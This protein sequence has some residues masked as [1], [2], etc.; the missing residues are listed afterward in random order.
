MTSVG[1]RARP[2]RTLLLA[3]TLLPVLLLA[4]R[5]LDMDS[6][7]VTDWLPQ[8]RPARTVYDRFVAQF[9]VDDYVLLSWPGCILDDPRVPRLAAALRQ[10]PANSSTRL[11]EDVTTGP[12]LLE[13]LTT[14]PIALPYAEA[15][16]RIRGLFVGPDHQTTCLSIRTGGTAADRQ[17]AFEHICQTAQETCGLDRG[18]L[19]VGGSTFE[20]VALNEASRRTLLRYAVPSGIVSLIVALLFQANPRLTGAVFLT[21]A[22][23]QLLA[24]AVL[25]VTLGRM[26]VLLI[27]M[28]TLVYVLTMSGAVHLA[29]YCLDSS[30]FGGWRDGVRRGMAIGRFPVL[31]TTGTTVLGVLSLCSSQIAP[32]RE[33]G[34]YSALSL[35]LSLWGQFVLL[36]A[37][38]T[39]GT[40]RRRDLEA[41]IGE[42]RWTRTI[43]SAGMQVAQ[44][45]ARRPVLTTVLTLLVVGAGAC[46]LVRLRASVDFD[47]MFPERSEVIRNFTWLE[48]SLGP[49]APIEV[50]ISVPRDSELSL[51]ECLQ[52]IDQIEQSL[53]SL[54]LVDGTLSAATY[55][56]RLP[57]GSRLQDLIQRRLWID[58]LDRRRPEFLRDHL[59]AEDAALE[60]WRIT[61]R[62]PARGVFEYRSLAR[63]AEE[64][65]RA[66]IA[67]NHPGGRPE[68]VVTS[69]GMLTVAEETNDQLFADLR[70]S[71]VT[72]FLLITPLM[73]LLLGGI[74]PGLMAMIPNVTPIMLVF[75]CMGWLGIP[76]EIGTILCASVALGI[77]VDDT[78]HFLTW[79]RVGIDDG[80]SRRDAVLLAY[81][82]C[83]VA[84]L[85][86]TMIC[87]CG[88]LVFGLSD[89]LPAARF[90]VLL[91]A[92]L[93]V[94]LLGDLVLLP[95]L[96]CAPLGRLFL[97][98]RSRSR[99]PLTRPT[100]AA[101]SPPLTG[102]T[103]AD[104]VAPP[105]IC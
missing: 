97:S 82:R 86:T 23:C 84:M 32:V 10:T 71:F 13:R 7:R 29:N 101:D 20:A 44:R 65:A 102:P 45:I 22:F 15:L 51:W 36:P 14:H 95:A 28:P 88:M 58:R 47:R 19:R 89:F 105:G 35:T 87:V 33:F 26:N 64:A 6:G 76:L 24:L 77:A 16:A 42:T 50:L 69:T 57:S 5:G 48:D 31:V 93:L 70:F 100:T 62:V 12:E 68:V 73:M 96:L 25:G 11:I 72:A 17:R 46:G 30:R 9:G 63:S 91:G 92:Q 78:V 60:T 56:P 90:A 74:I 27:L 8:G 43:R 99:K 104:G 1:D 67:A 61:L 40:G 37:L 52:L 80:L 3:G 39:A 41:G 54:P 79:F 53:K 2:E 83:A 38:L 4:A 18:D 103:S 94:T 59:L 98:A 81:D 55:L 66:V 49:L 21:A 75:G 34:G 85:Q